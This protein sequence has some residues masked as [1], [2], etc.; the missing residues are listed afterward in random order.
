[1]RGI[2]ALNPTKGRILA[3][4]NMMWISIANEFHEGMCGRFEVQFC[5]SSPTPKQLT[6]TTQQTPTWCLLQVLP[7]AKFTTAPY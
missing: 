7:L 1:M 3:S 5:V 6:R 2:G 4:R